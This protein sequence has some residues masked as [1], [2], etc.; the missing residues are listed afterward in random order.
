MTPEPTHRLQ[1]EI[2]HVLVVDLVDYSQRP[3]AE[4]IRLLGQLQALLRKTAS[5]RSAEASEELL[6]IPTGDGMAL[7]FFR[8][9][10]AAVQCALELAGALRDSADLKLRMGIH[11][12]P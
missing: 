10:A 2:A 1:L 9:P 8:D 3:M 7:V 11:S 5:F 4:Q 12:G 6:R